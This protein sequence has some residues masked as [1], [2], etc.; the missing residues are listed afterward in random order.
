MYKY[1]TID[2]KFYLTIL[3]FILT[4]PAQ[5]PPS[6]ENCRWDSARSCTPEVR[7]Q[8]ALRRKFNTDLDQLKGSPSHC[9]REAGVPITPRYTHHTT[10]SFPSRGELSGSPADIDPPLQRRK[11]L[12]TLRKGAAREAAPTRG[13]DREFQDFRR[14]PAPPKNKI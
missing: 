7:T 9:A 13:L 12:P 2:F 10:C 11:R 1:T 3:K 8:C 4:F 5:K 14:S 6:R